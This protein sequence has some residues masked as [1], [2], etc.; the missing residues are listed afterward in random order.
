MTHHLTA[1]PDAI[2]LGRVPRPTTGPDLADRLRAGLQQVTA[3]AVEGLDRARLEAT[4]DGPDVPVLLVD[5]TGVTVRT[6]APASRTPGVGQVAHREQG[7]LR[8]ASVTAHPVT[9]A[10]VPAHLDAVLDGLTFTWLEGTDGALAVALV[11]PGEETPVSGQA[12]LAVDRDRLVEA[13]RER[14]AETLAAQGFALSSLEVDLTSHGPTS[15]GVRA[16]A[17][18]RK[19]MLTAVARVA[20]TVEVSDDLVLTVRD[21]E[22]TSR[23]PLVAALL[24][25]FRSRLEAVEGR[26]VDLGAALPPGVRVQELR[27]DVGDELVLTVRLA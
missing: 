25:A 11:E 15:V 16:D 24:V 5:L 17:K 10:G 27:L 18:V 14:L 6:R 23:N 12:R 1:L 22:A 2:P 8:T 19:G 4:V 20:A 26:R 21:V 7:A 3:G 9:V 13:T